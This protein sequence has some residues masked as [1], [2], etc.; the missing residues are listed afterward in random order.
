MASCD[1]LFELENEEAISSSCPSV[2]TV[3]GLT[4]GGLLY[5]RVQPEAAFS[6]VRAEPCSEFCSLYVGYRLYGI[7]Q[8]TYRCLLLFNDLVEYSDE[9]ERRSVHRPPRHGQAVAH[10]AQP[11][12]CRVKGRG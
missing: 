10:T 4:Y 8:D 9:V 2:A 12:V 6:T 7:S 11:R 1:F 5:A 3:L